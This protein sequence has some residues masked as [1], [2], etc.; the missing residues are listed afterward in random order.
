MH[1]VP[2]SPTLSDFRRARLEERLGAVTAE[3]LTLRA[4]AMTFVDLAR[5]LSSAEETRLNRLLD[6]PAEFPKLAGQLVLV[7]PRPGTISPWSS[8]ATEIAH[9][10][11][12]SGVRRLEHGMAYEIERAGSGALDRET[13][14]ACARALHDRMTE[15]TLDALD[16]AACLFASPQTRPLRRIDLLGGGR[17]ALMRA[18]RELG[19]A[20]SSD[21]IDYLCDRFGA[22]GRNPTDVELMMFAQANSE[23]CRHK[24]FNA[25]WTIDGV[26]HA[27]SLFA[28]IRETTANAPAGVLSAYADNA[29][30]IEGADAGRF[31]PAATDGVYRRNA[32]PVHIM[33]KVETHNHPTAIAPDP[34]AATGAGGEIRDE[35][36]TGRGA[37][38]KAGLVGFTV[39]DLR[40]P[41]RTRPWEHDHGKPERIVSA[42]EIM[43]EGPIGAAR[44]GNEFGRPCLTGYFRTLTH[45]AA[46][47]ALYGYHKPIMIAGGYGNIRAEHVEKAAFPAGTPLV[48]L[49]GPALLIG[50]GGGA[51]SS[52]AS[53][54]SAAD[55]DFA[56][57]QRANPEMQRR[58]QEAIDRCWAL[59]DD[60]PIRFIHDVGAGGLSNALPELVKDAGRG[61]TFDLAAIPN[62]DPA[63][64]P[65][66]V[67]CNEAQERYVLAIDAARLAAFEAICRR[68]RCPYAI[69]GAAS[70]DEH[71]I[72]EDE[73]SGTRAI[74]VPLSLLFDQTPRMV[75][76]AGRALG[77]G[78]SIDTDGIDLAEAAMRVL[79]L[80]AVAAKTFLVTI[81]DRSVGGL[82]VRDQMVGP[83]QVPVAD[84]AVTLSDFGCTRGEAMAMGERTPLAIV[85]PAASG[86]MAV[87]E[88]LTNIAAAAIDS[89]GSIKLSANWMAA[90]GHPGV[91]R[92]LYETVQ[93]VGPELCRALGIAIPVGKDSMSMKTVWQD[94]DGRERVMTSPLSV[95]I[96]AFA[97]VYD[98]RATATPQL[99]LDA[100]DSRLILIDLGG[101]LDRLGGSALAQVFEL[102]GG[103]CPDLDDA[104][105]LARF[106]AA[107]QA[108]K[109]TGLL[110]AYH[111]RSDGGLFVTLCEMAFAG[112]CGLTIELNGLGDN[113]LTAL[114][115]E[116][117]GAV[118]QVASDH[119]DAAMSLLAEHGLGNAS[120][121]IARPEQGKRVLFAH[122][123]AVLYEAERA[124]LQRIW[125]ETSFALQ[126]LRD[127]PECAREEFARIGDADPGLSPRLTFDPATPPIIRRSSERP[128][129]AIL[130]EQGVNG[131]TEMAAAFDRAGFE[132]VDI[133][134]SDV[135][136]GRRDLT[137]CI[138]LA[139]CGGFSYGDVL[140]AGA[141]WAKSVLFDERA[142]D[143]FQAFFERK[144]TFALGV[145]NGCQMLSQLAE[146]IP[147]SDHWPRFLPNRSGQ[148]EARLVTVEVLETP[149]IFMSGMV[150]SRLPIVVAHGE[151]RA[152]FD[153]PRRLDVAAGRI[154]LRYVENDGQSAE[155]YPANPNGSPLGITGLTSADGR[156]DIMM[157]H[158]ERVFLTDQLSWHPRDWPEDG[159]W[160]R[161]FQ[162]ARAWVG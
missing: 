55:L 130:R 25:A 26:A 112:R 4:R 162:N 3:R 19:L 21:E 46:D 132:C 124:D 147:G 128:R 42:L 68:E 100:G 126:S 72:L 88:A 38:P 32:E 87:G 13:L 51:A 151:G 155:R 53:G 8:R 79:R 90:A 143:V 52:M 14:G 102:A 1:T 23:H 157:P 78:A 117:L 114:F 59:G 62:A 5:P 18:D 54:T 111:D 9:R 39:S 139:A 105:R 93:A 96:S 27:R 109:R 20:L 81:A 104:D 67:W 61:G 47:G 121:I 94:A 44:F 6:A 91:D 80:P 101:G 45:A 24:I 137:D 153:D 134:M 140:G 133:H 28:M 125:S 106:F 75:R 148:F 74:D 12:L 63:M 34:G 118:I 70:E 98:T 160:L 86:R 110:L 56:S 99:R 92:A 77:P 119:L 22:I 149:S 89:L 48:V 158:P 135:L 129:V 11:G 150:G 31:Y 30:V 144:D 95:I 154:T 113:M 71:L 141:G 156:V 16:A 50:L 161:L 123:G 120:T 41:G 103:P 97:P 116:E 58:C 83:W 84:V 107:V 57:V 136:A 122:K 82:V 40:L 35:G 15:I 159:P 146:L 33:M 29:A 37:K 66:E 127:H 142:R 152:T 2:G 138:G 145:C 115:S 64:S 65:M 131:Q 85:D 76:E 60:N 10:C 36:A 69:V 49:G 43:L 108:L 7:V 17:D 73:R